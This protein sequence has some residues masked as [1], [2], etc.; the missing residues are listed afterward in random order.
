MPP[1]KEVKTPVMVSDCMIANTLP[2]TTFPIDACQPAAMDP[3]NTWLAGLDNTTRRQHTCDRPKCTESNH[4]GD[5]DNEESTENQCASESVVINPVPDVAA[6]IKGV[7]D[8]VLELLQ[9]GPSGLAKEP[10]D[11]LESGG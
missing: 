10:G 4:G 2:A 8:A 3:S 11:Y 7:V 5:R 9:G 1:P 6:G